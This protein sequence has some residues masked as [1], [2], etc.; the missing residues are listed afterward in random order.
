MNKEILKK[1]SF[2]LLLLYLIVFSI[3]L[4]QMFILNVVP[5]YLVISCICFCIALF[6]LCLC[7]LIKKCVKTGKILLCVFIIIGLFGNIYIYKTSKL[8]NVIT[9]SKTDASKVYV[10]ALKDHNHFSKMGILSIGNLELQDKALKK[11]NNTYEL[12]EYSSYKEYGNALYDGKVDTLLVSDGSYSLMEESFPTFKKD[13]KIIETINVEIEK[14]DS[15]E[16]VDIMNKPFNIYIS[17]KDANDLNTSLSRSDVNIIVSIN[18]KTHQILMTGIPRDYFIPQTCQ[19]NQRDKLTHTGLYGIN[20]TIDSVSNYMNIPIDYYVQVNFNSLVNVVDALGGITI[21]CPI[22]FTSLHGNYHFTVG[23]NDM[24]GLQA[25]GF[26]RER[27]SFV[28]GDRERSR[29]QMRVLTAIINKAMTPSIIIKYPQFMDA[30]SDSFKTNLTQKQMTSFIK[31]Q[32][33]HASKWDI[34]QIQVNGTGSMVVSPALGFEVYVMQPNEETVKNATRLI[35]KINSG[36]KITRED[37]DSQL[38]LMN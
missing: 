7:L 15:K 14:N 10:V 32:I 2:Y 3:L 34:Q 22:E 27:Y 23:K 8:F 19:N 29:N 25:L 33:Q 16:D 37:I 4:Y 1:G 36:E 35:N 11:I 6:L 18:P 9:D 20:C 13:T 28:D 21:D 31:E 17:G 26:V 30:L 12:K 24:N 38:K 5:N